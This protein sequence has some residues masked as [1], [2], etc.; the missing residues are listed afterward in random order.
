MV[1]YNFFNENSFLFIENC[2]WNEWST[3]NEC[4]GGCTGQGVRYRS[5]TKVPAEGDGED[6]K[7]SY[8]E[9]EPCSS[10]NCTVTEWSEWTDCSK[11]CGTGEKS[12]KRS[13]LS[14][15]A[16]CNLTLSE[17][18]F[19]NI[20]C[21]PVD[22]KWSP[23]STWSNCSATCG[24]GLQKRSRVCNYPSPSCIGNPCEGKDE[25]VDFCI[26]PPC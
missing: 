12:R 21:C 4:V 23:W 13:L 20:Q 2:T 1:A 22:G 6:C 24:T 26:L 17:K 25:E 18:E 11:S 3:W 10:C 14:T 7:G 15:N 9:K 5:R 16:T 8:F 19:C